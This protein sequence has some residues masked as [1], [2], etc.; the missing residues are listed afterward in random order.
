M[1]VLIVQFTLQGMDADTYITLTGQVA[2]EIAAAPGLITKLWLDGND[3]EKF[4]GVYL[5]ENQ[6]AID[7]Y[8][9]SEPVREFFESGVCGDLSISTIDLLEEA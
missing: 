5:F 3:G 7:A 2:P 1:K 4:G 6:A 8:L 9:A